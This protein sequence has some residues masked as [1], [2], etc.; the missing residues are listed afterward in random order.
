MRFPWKVKITH[1]I[2]MCFSWT[3]DLN[4]RF[5]NTR[6]IVIAYGL[7]VIVG[8]LIIKWHIE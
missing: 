8:D 6:K 7:M 5:E 3:V 4:K 1:V 2:H